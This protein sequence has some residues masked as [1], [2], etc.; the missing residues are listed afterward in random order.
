MEAGAKECRHRLTTP[1]AD[2]EDVATPG[3]RSDP[4]DGRVAAQG[5]DGQDSGTGRDLPRGIRSKGSVRP[6]FARSSSLWLTL[7]VP[8]SLEAALRSFT[9][10]TKSDIIE[11]TYNSLTFEFLIMEVT[12]EG[13]GINIIDTDL[14]VSF[15][16]PGGL[17]GRQC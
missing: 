1:S 7:R 3:R 17:S 8:C 13:P 16:R 15:G 2:D 4:V 5:K 10:L 12:P 14:E 11:I 9:T 6:A